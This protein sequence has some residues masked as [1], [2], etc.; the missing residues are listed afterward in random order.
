MIINADSRED[1]HAPLT[2]SDSVSAFLKH[3]GRIFLDFEPGLDR[4]AEHFTASLTRAAAC[5]PAPLDV[6]AQPA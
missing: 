2:H 5:S 3:H 4:L 6:G 1:L